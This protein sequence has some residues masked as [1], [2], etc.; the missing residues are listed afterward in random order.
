MKGLWF[1]ICSI[2]FPC[3]SDSL[4]D[5]LLSEK[6]EVKTATKDTE[7][8]SEPRT[9]RRYTSSPMAMSKVGM[10]TPGLTPI[11]GMKSGWLSH[12]PSISDSLEHNTPWLTEFSR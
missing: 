5:G 11:S 12:I 10:M 6:E 9:R 4:H 8:D 1:E 7:D 2:L 3:C